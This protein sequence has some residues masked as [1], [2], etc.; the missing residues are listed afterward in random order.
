MSDITD[1]LPGRHH[2]IAPR[3]SHFPVVVSLSGELLGVW[4]I[5]ECRY[6]WISNH[7]GFQAEAAVAKISGFER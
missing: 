4:I 2:G 7:D 3:H 6:R 5:P 1:T